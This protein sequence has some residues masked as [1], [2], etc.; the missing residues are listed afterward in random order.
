MRKLYSV[1]SFSALLGMA[2]SCSDI[3][4]NDVAVSEAT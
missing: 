2:A 1:L 3:I 4:E